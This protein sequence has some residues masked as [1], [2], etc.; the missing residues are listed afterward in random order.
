MISIQTVDQFEQVKEEDGAVIMFTAGWCPDCVVI[1][2]EVPAIEEKFS[3][4][5]FYK[6]DRDTFIEQCQE[7]EIFGI[8]SF[9]LFKNG[10]EAD[11]FVSKDRKTREEIERFI[12]EA[13]EK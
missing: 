11:R 5:S 10:R 8:P 2:P 12:E 7:L 6:M 13:M 4:L 3:D 1:E 9:L